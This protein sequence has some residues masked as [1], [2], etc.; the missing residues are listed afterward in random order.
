MFEKGSGE[1][2]QSMQN[3][4]PEMKGFSPTNKSSLQ[5]YLPKYASTER[6]LLVHNT[7]TSAQD[8]SFTKTSPIAIYWCFC[9]NANKYIEGRQPDYTLFLAEKCTIGTDSLASNWSLSILD[10]LKTI[11]QKNMQI[12]LETL[13]K[14]AT[15]NGAEALGLT[16]KLGSIEVGKAPGLNLISDLIDANISEKSTVKKIV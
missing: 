9:P 15:I 12:E 1:L 8:I 4:A 16:D 14:W 13:L 10:E 3:F 2:L 5:S 11:R 7:F 6:M